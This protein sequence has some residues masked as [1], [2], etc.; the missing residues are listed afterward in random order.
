MPL[1][2]NDTCHSIHYKQVSISELEQAT[3][4][5]FSYISWCK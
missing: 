4:L 1:T 5:L 2:A 3:S